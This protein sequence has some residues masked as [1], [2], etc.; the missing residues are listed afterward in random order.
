VA[1]DRRT[2]TPRHLLDLFFPL[3]AARRGNLL[4]ADHPVEDQVQQAVLAAHVPVQRSR[5]GVEVLGDP[6]HAQAVEPIPVEDAQRGL[7]DRLDRDRVAP[8]TARRARGALPG[9]R[10][11]FRPGCS[12][13]L[14]RHTN[15][16]RLANN[17]WHGTDIYT[18]TMFV[19]R[20]CSIDDGC[21]REGRR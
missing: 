1:Q 19:Q 12:G 13:V 3:A 15:S 4:L 20:P 7:D 9:R 18:R 11:Q 5:A 14:G 8:A 21:S 6:A 10:R 2:M 16:V 17:A